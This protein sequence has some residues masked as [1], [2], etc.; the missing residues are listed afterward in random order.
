MFWFSGS[1]VSIFT[2]MITIQF[3]TSPLKAISNINE[4]FKAYEHKDVNLI[5]P[6]LMYAGFNIGLF[7]FAVYKFASMGCLPVT[8]HDWIGVISSRVSE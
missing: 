5:L 6:K 3:L 8:P 4:M 2:L 1:G 7:G